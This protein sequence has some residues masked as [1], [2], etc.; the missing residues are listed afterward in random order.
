LFCVIF[1]EKHDSFIFFVEIM[2]HLLP[3]LFILSLAAVADD[4]TFRVR[5]DNAQIE[6]VILGCSAKATDQYDKGLDIYAPPMSMGTAI[7]GLLLDRQ[8]QMIL[9]KD[10]RA[11]KLPQAWLLDCKL[12]QK[13]P[14]T[15]S[16]QPDK[17]PKDLLCTIQVPKQQ[18]LDMRKANRC[19]VNENGIVVIT[20]TKTPTEKTSE[21][22]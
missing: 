5:M 13:K 9:Y 3:I 17:L 14:L 19:K 12:S 22:K 1:L 4:F 15:L 8:S 11:D 7:A 10:I 6:E 16:W 20:F 18:P 2:K 21:Q